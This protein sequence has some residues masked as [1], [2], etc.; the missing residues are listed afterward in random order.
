MNFCWK[1]G[2][3][4]VDGPCPACGATPESRRPLPEDASAEAR[5]LRRI[6]D[7][8]GPRQVLS[9][10]VMLYNGL[11]DILGEDGQA[12][13]NQVRIVMDSGLG[14]LY[15]AQLIFALPNFPARVTKLITDIGF[16]T[17]T[18][19]YLMSLFDDMTGLPVE[20]ETEEPEQA[21]QEKP[22]PVAPVQSQPSKRD[23]S[24]WGT[25][26]PDPVEEDDDNPTVLGSR[27]RRRS[28]RSI[29][30][31]GS[32]EGKPAKA[33]D[34]SEAGNGSV[35]AWTTLSDDGLYDLTIAGNGGVRLPEDAR[36]LF[37][38]YRQAKS[39]SF[40]QCTDT[41]QITDMRYMFCDCHALTAL[42]LSS[43][44]TS[45]VTDMGWMFLDCRGLTTLDLSSFD[46]SQVFDMSEMFGGCAA[47]TTLDL[48]SFDTSQVIYMQ[49]MFGGCAALTTLDLSSFDTSQLTDMQ[50]MFDRCAAL[51]TLDLSSFDTSRVT[52]MNRLFSDCPALKTVY[53]SS[54]F[55]IPEDATDM[56]FNCPLQSIDDFTD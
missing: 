23:P 46:T 56:F 34:V 52:Y 5:A 43:F 37:E 48:S 15:Q 6:Y 28:I 32:L 54:K 8:Y 30:F 50:E 45:R 14:R 26:R 2:E 40:G 11:G 29:T 35:W 9:R 19:R 12:L 25:L 17:E 22:E 53:V 20:E 51:T 41:S 49:E 47:L 10:T 44:D 55:V 31:L 13:R 36:D 24:G 39:I 4:L 7:S 3:K 18:A 33:W 27:Y 1:C 16:T 38:D 21:V 42:D